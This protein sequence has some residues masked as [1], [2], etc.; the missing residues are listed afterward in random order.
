[1][2]N[3]AW[4]KAIA[5]VTLVTQINAQITLTGCHLHEGQES[6]R[7]TSLRRNMA[8]SNVEFVF[9]PVVQKPLFHQPAKHP[10]LRT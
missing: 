8:D 2:Y 3:M 7:N 5:V 10:Q 4:I 1:M 6:A 9:Y